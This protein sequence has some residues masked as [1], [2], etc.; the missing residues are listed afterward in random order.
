MQQ[1]SI[2]PLPCLV[3]GMLIYR[4]VS[5]DYQ[6]LYLVKTYYIQIKPSEISLA[7]EKPSPHSI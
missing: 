7:T 2:K 6:R 4:S 5:P 1:V 3:S